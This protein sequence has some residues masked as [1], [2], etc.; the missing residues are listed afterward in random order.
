MGRIQMNFLHLLTSEA[1]QRVTVRCLDTPV[2]ATGPSL[3]P[4]SRAL[5]FRAWNGEVIQAGDLLEPQVTRD[6]CWVRRL[7]G[8]PRSHA[9]TA[10]LSGSSA[11]SRGTKGTRN[12]SF[13]LFFS[14]VYRSSFPFW[15]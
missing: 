1:W 13:V 14:N 12:F 9:V 3:Q 15:I 6:D 11:P 10:V 8:G 7:A 5:G 2:W 4:S